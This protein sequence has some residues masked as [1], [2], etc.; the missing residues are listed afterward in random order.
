ML[1]NLYYFCLIFIFYILVPRENDGSQFGRHINLQLTYSFQQNT[2]HTLQQLSSNNNSNNINNN[3]NNNNNSINNNN[4]T[5]KS[6]L[7][8]HGKF[9]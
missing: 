4:I 7:F 9:N 8:T 3:N 1:I 6:G 5:S 2:N